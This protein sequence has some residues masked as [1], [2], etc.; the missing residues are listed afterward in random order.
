VPLESAGAL[1]DATEGDRP[2]DAALYAFGR[3]D[4]GAD[5]AF[6]PR[7][8]AAARAALGRRGPARIFALRAL[9]RTK[10]AGVAG[11]L[12]RVMGSHDSTAS[13]RVEAA[14]ALGRLGTA[15]QS[16]LAGALGTLV[17][18]DV[19]GLGG[20]EYGVLTAGVGAVSD[21]AIKDAATTLGRLARV[22]MK[23]G[24][25]PPIL[26]RASAVRCAAAA[27]IARGAWDADLLRACD[28]AD[29]EAGQRA[30]LT[31]LDRGSFTRA[32][33]TAWLELA[34]SRHLRVREAA[35]E[36]ASHHPELGEALIPVLADALSAG[37]PGLVA[38]A[39]TALHSHPERAYVLAAS[40]RRAALDPRAPPPSATP[41]R[42]VDP[43]IGKALRAALARA[44]APDL[45]ETRTALVDA[46]FA[47]SLPEARPF[48]LAA[49][50]DTNTTVR[51]RAAKALASA[52][53]KDATCP[54]PDTADDAA[55]EIGHTLGRPT[56][57]IFETDAGATLAI[58][59]DPAFAPIAATRFVALAEA[60]FYTGVSVHRVV[61][62]FVAQFGD[63]GGDGYGGSGQ[64]LRC[65]T[66]PQAFGA[67]DVG[68]A[69]AGRDTG[70]S[71]LFVTLSRHPH[72]DGEYAWVGRAEGDWDGVAEGD[73]M[74]T[75]QVDGTSEALPRRG[76]NQEE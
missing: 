2:L 1:L 29:G 25:L 53:E 9:G 4:L 54:P 34:H 71:Q 7:V 13:E 19:G 6:E 8:V 30:T 43:R 3:I 73:V 76:Q 72:L 59:F 36:V 47:V 17:P 20:D 48:A 56:R 31:A 52:G 27:K 5:D 12:A 75:V 68:V 51:A 60:G 35:I 42:E 74:R 64:T 21:E 46:A 33:R 55:Q 28:I 45:V 22:P 67:L 14:R 65:E 41:A 10:D 66:S 44:L 38:T 26:R 39:A 57:V 40:E 32:R 69:L 50:H 16:A 23:E 63:H 49:C 70:S 61:P 18:D 24:A 37:E 62:G 11:D 58:V 15:G